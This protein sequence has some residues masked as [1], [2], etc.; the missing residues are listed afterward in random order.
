MNTIWWF[1]IFFLLSQFFFRAATNELSENNDDDDDDDEAY[2]DADVT[3]APDKTTL[4]VKTK[5]T[6]DDIKDVMEES[7]DQRGKTS[8]DYEE[9]VSMEQNQ[10]VEITTNKASEKQ[11]YATE[12]GRSQMKFGNMTNTTLSEFED[13]KILMTKMAE[14]NNK[15]VIIICSVIGSTLFLI[16]IIMLCLLDAISDVKH[17]TTDKL[18]EAEEGRVNN[19]K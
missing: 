18:I 15:N 14:K 5:D 12:E 10:N 8:D 9:D 4:A 3:G 7:T 6:T 13:I 17:A 2:N 16:I 11:E 1:F 19:P